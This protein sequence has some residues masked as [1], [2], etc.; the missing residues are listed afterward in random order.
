MV[1]EIHSLCRAAPFKAH[2]DP[3]TQPRH[4]EVMP[5]EVWEVETLST[6]LRMNLPQLTQLQGLLLSLAEAAEPC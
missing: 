5:Q 4:T 6:P 1:T 2:A 3:D